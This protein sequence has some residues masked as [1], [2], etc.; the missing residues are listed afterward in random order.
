VSAVTTIEHQAAPRYQLRVPIMGTQAHIITV[1]GEPDLLDDARERLTDLHTK[2]T[3]FDEDSEVSRINAAAGH[4]VS[5]SPETVL[6]VGLAVTAWAWTDGRYD[7]SVLPAVVAAGYDR[8]FAALNGSSMNV[9]AAHPAR[10]CDGV[11]VNAERSTVTIPVGTSLDYGGIAKGLAADIIVADLLDGGAIGACV[12]IGGDL[13][14]SGV[15]PRRGGWLVGIDHPQGHFLSGCVRITDGGV[16]TT[17]RMKRTWGPTS[18]NLHHV[19]D[20]ATG[21]P[22]RTNVQAVTVVS[23][24]GWYAEALAKAAFLAGP[25]AGAE[26]LTTAGASGFFFCDGD[27]TFAVGAWNEMSA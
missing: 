26:L 25:S 23:D 27:E 18:C 4:P 16:A 8:D 19:I 9:A 14:A 13:R 17:S 3:R 1:Q 20:P 10:G 21:A 15:S 24:E 2:W 11:T 5:V 6:L 12:N 7:P 22:A